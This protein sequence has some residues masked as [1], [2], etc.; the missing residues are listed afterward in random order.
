MGE[1]GH[2]RRG[3]GCN[4]SGP[5]VSLCTGLSLF[6]WGLEFGLRVNMYKSTLEV[7]VRTE[8]RDLGLPLFLLAQ[9]AGGGGV[10]WGQSRGPRKGRPVPGGA[11]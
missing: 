5:P 4:E 7:Q 6:V 2:L 1:V 8:C 3:V 11:G 10:G 9:G